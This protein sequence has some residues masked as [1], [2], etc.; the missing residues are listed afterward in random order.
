MCITNRHESHYS[1]LLY[2]HIAQLFIFY[3]NGNYEIEKKKK[4]IVLLHV[5]CVCT[6]THYWYLHSY[7]FAHKLL[8]YARK[9]I[10]GVDWCF[11]PGSLFIW[12][13][14]MMWF[15]WNSNGLMLDSWL[16]R[17]IKNAKTHA[18]TMTV[19]I[20]W[21]A[22]SFEKWE[23]NLCSLLFLVEMIWNSH[24]SWL[25]QSWIVWIRMNMI[26]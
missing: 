3:W 18:S 4:E 20:Q 5:H 2:R 9:I 7:S 11:V 14:L 24:E 19:S 17:F 21:A 12:L 25:N 10:M 16:L 13:H 15:C 6:R 22:Q 1:I 23:L 8:Y 26:S